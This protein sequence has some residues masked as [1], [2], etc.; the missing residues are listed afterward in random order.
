MGI[1]HK[2]LG[3]R[4]SEIARRLPGR[5]DNHVKNHWYSFMRRNVR[6]LNKEVSS[7]L[8]NQLSSGTNDGNMVKDNL[9]DTD[10][11]K[12]EPTNQQPNQAQTK[13]RKEISGKVANLSELKLYFKS[14]EEAANEVIEELKLK[15]SEGVESESDCTDAELNDIIK[16]ASGSLEPLNSPQRMTTLQLASGNAIFRYYIYIMK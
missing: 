4:W 13:K 7:V 2:E 10:T 14:A 9:V 3:N 6:R 1:A 12:E 11:R 5:T 16:L 8:P 15:R